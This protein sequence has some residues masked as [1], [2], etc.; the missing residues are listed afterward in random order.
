MQ[1]REIR[2]GGFGI[3]ANTRVRGLSS[4]VNILFGENEFGK[5][6]VL[7]LVRRILFGFPTKGS[8]ANQYQVLGGGQHSGTLVCELADGRTIQVLRTTGKS[9][10]PVTVQTADGVSADP[11]ALLNVLGNVSENLYNNVFAI[12]LQEL[13][14]AKQLQG[15]DV[16][17]RIYGAGLGLGQVSLSD[18]REELNKKATDLYRPHGSVQEMNSLAGRLIDIEKDLKQKRAELA[19]YDELTERLSGLEESTARMKEEQAKRNE[20]QF[21]LRNEENLFGTYVELS[22]SREERHGMGQ[23]A[24][25]RPETMDKF[26]GL[27]E[28]VASLEERIAEKRAQLR[29]S[30]Q[31]LDRIHYDPALLEQQA[32]IKSLV[33]SLSQYRDAREQMPALEEKHTAE[34]NQI[35][36]R[37]GELGNGWDEERAR[38]FI[39]S[40]EARDQLRIRENALE[41]A[42]AAADDAANRLELHRQN[43]RA[44]AGMSLPTQYRL[45]GTLVLAVGAA[46]TAVALVHDQFAIAILSGIAAAIGL[47]I[48]LAFRTGHSPL[49]DKVAQELETTFAAAR[50][51]Y[52]EAQ[53]EWSAFLES[54]GLVSSLSPEGAKDQLEAIDGTRNAL[55]GADETGARIERLAE[56]LRNTIDTYARVVACLRSPIEGRDNAANIEVLGDLVQEARDAKTISEGLSLVIERTTR[57]VEGLEKEMASARSK[58]EALL[59]TN[60]VSTREQ[61]EDLCSRS[62]RAR[63]LDATIQGAERIIRATV[64]TGDSLETF[65]SAIEQSSPEGIHAELEEL[66]GAIASAEG[67]LETANQDMWS[68]EERLKTLASSGV[69]LETEARAEEVRQKL[70]D[71]RSDWLVVRISLRALDQAISRYETTRQ[72]E[73]IR[74]AQT[75]FERMTAGRYSAVLCPLGSTQLRV[76]DSNGTDKLVDELSRGTRE[77]LYLAMRMGLI[78]QYEQNAEPLPVIMDDILVNFDDER[79]PLAVQALAEFAKDRQVIVMTCHQS[80]LELYRKVGAREL[81]VERDPALL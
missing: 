7:E 44:R 64:G 23:F 79:G 5:T 74:Q 38:G 69:V 72:P 39:L 75:T 52:G 56:T 81:S 19:E 24:L 31:D 65:L 16:R 57:E 9:G 32:D 2:I 17:D 50:E 67:E 36:Q 62:D 22:E 10:G 54:I 6:T 26:I 68:L 46:G 41:K 80:T 29:D 25:A 4:G 73:V 15:E 47:A 70:Q 34:R 18:L 43:L 71:A 63:E 28:E 30:L 13:Q 8:G 37:L 40:T 66:N 78:A 11:S 1:L 48:A 61:L 53:V 76:R 77:Q 59:S 49:Q 27:Q 42:R 21:L 33:Q 60:G 51:R 14:A 12:S 45:L 35:S 55:R 3:F 58:I 20:R